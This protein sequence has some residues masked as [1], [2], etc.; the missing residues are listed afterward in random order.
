M[1]STVTPASVVRHS[2]VNTVRWNRLP[3]LLFHVRREECVAPLQTT[4]LSSVYVPLVGKVHA[5]VK[6]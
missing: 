3:V 6:M 5:A 1:E 4:P 2:Q